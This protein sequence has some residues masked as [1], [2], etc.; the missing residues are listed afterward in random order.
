M[1]NSQCSSNGSADIN[2]CMAGFLGLHLTPPST[3]YLEVRRTRV[4]N[5]YKILTRNM[6][7]VLGYGSLITTS[8]L[9]ALHNLTSI[10][11]EES[12]LSLLGRYG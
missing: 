11:V 6:I 4:F 9:Q 10:P 12:C 5:M 3:A 2:S 1:Q 7:R 8:T